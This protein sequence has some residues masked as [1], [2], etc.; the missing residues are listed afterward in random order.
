MPLSNT[1]RAQNRIANAVFF[2]FEQ[3]GKFLQHVDF[4][5]S[6]F[7]P[8]ENVGRSYSYRRPGKLTTFQTAP[9]ARGAGPDVGSVPSYG[10][11]TEPVLTMSI[12]QKFR[13]AIAISADDLSM[14]VTAEQ[15]WSRGIRQGAAAMRRQIETYAA[16]VAMLGAGQVVG[17]PG[18]P[19][20]G[21]ALLDNYIAAAGLMTNRGL[22]DD[23][24]RIALVPVAQANSL[25]AVHRTLFNPQSDVSKVF[26]GGIKALGQVGGLNFGETSLLPSDQIATGSY[27][28]PVVNGANQSAGSVWAQTWSMITSGWAPNQVIPAG[29]LASISNAGDPIRWVVP[30]VFTDT[31]V[32]AT[33]RVVST[34][35]AT[36][37][38]AATLTLTEPLIGPTGTNGY[39]NVTAL[40][41]NGATITL[42]NAVAAAR[43]GLVMHSGSVLGASTAV[44]VPDNL[45][46]K[47]EEVDGVKLTLVKTY[48]PF[49]LSQIWELQALVG[50]VA[51]IPEGLVTVH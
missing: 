4:K 38:G 25:V 6:D 40:P 41:A 7:K 34:V 29:A 1:V 12:A 47:T 23:G 14:D 13:Q 3:A 37:G 8:S 30:D 51:G 35:T 31:G 15:A 2:E 26:R 39:Q 11:Y 49:N 36:A 33:F 17:T 24:K 10:S 44:K 27:G 46:S 16:Q 18:T 45:Y 5:S 19:S 20:T 9:A 42:L 32:T 48:D 43:P 21:T 50:F 28:T 22:D